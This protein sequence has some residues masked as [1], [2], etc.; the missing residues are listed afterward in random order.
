MSKRLQIDYIDIAEVEFGDKTSLADGKLTINKKELLGLV[1]SELFAFMDIHLAVP[2]ESCR[3]LAIHDVMQ[4]RCKADAPE[5]SYPG[6][7]GKLAPA[8]EGRT[9]ALRGVMVSEIYYAKCNIKYYMDM[10]G[11]CA[12][13]THFAKHFHVIID[14][15]PAEG[16]SDVSYAEALKHAALTV[17]VHLA[18]LG[19]DKT[20]DETEVF[21]LTPVAPGPDGKTLPKVA[22]MVTHMASHDIWN[23]LLYGQ[24]ALNFLPFIIHPTEVLDGAMLWR[25][26]EPNYYLQ[27]E[28]YIREL[29][30][31]HGKDLEFVG[32]VITNNVMK[33]DSKETMGMIGAS[34]C[35]HT[36]GA[37]CV[38]LNKS[39]MG[40]CQLDS[41]L[42]FKWCE[43]MGMP[44]ALNLSA[45][46]NELPGD[47][48]VI[49]DPSIDAV[50]N[51]GRNF[52][53]EHPR[54][55]RLIGEHANV[56]SLLGFDPWG[57]FTH[58]TNFAYQ[59]IWS[60]LGDC[61]ATT[62]A[63]LPAIGGR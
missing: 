32:I 8:G 51:S 1:H 40:H 25:Y 29:M 60:Q 45:V 13:Y 6:I 56:P 27:N 62:D 61:Y 35:K 31:R 3:I 20:P 43:N 37:D 26:W 48:L 24:S 4:P 50:I 10:G 28:I 46:S 5:T 2:G 17:N 33:I 7:W 63:N 15:A 16:V 21:E 42:A 12:E 11:P 22:Y 36:L 53:L 18:K 55:N 38:M 9:V 54:V 19:I 49:S 41:A 30:K 57:P 34:L 47:M 39:G 23:F 44:A 52:D 58:T 14:A 59:G